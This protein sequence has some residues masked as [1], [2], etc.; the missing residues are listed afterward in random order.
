MPSR[1]SGSQRSGQLIQLL[2][3]GRS[4]AA[5]VPHGCD[6]GCH[7]TYNLLKPPL[8][9]LLS[10]GR[11]AAAVTLH[12]GSLYVLGGYSG[13]RQADGKPYNGVHPGDA[14]KLNVRDWKRQTAPS[15]DNTED[16]SEEHTDT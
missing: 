15:I 1:M 12:N 13:R 10:A 9:T 14:W 8:T 16:R 6:S 7:A 3:A 4:A 11:S 5:G 2:L